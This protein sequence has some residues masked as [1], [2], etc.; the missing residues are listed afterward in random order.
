MTGKGDDEMDFAAFA[1][2]FHDTAYNGMCEELGLLNREAS[3]GE[4]SSHLDLT[5]D[6]YAA[7]HDAW[8]LRACKRVPG[9]K[10]RDREG[11]LLEGGPH[12]S[13]RAKGWGLLKEAFGQ[14]REGVHRSRWVKVPQVGWW[15]RYVDEEGGGEDEED[16]EAAG[17]EETEAG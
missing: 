1:I 15:L 12:R 6:I 17:G 9:G 8:R 2:G 11:T 3:R 13:I 14:L 7:T 5:A 4:G 10:E 16:E